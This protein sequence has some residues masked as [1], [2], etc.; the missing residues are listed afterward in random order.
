MAVGATLNIINKNKIDSWPVHKKLFDSLVKSVLL[1]TAPVW[2]L[3]YLN[4]LE[5]VQMAFIKRSL[6][7]PKYIPNHF[8]RLETG[9]TPLAT[10]IFKAC[11]NWLEK[12]QKMGNNRYPKICYNKIRDIALKSSECKIVKYNWVKQ[13]Q[14][15]FYTDEY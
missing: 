10:N 14:K 6:N 11:I 12:L 3:R 5:K 1:Y 13:V 8:V 15:A 7:L 4:D 9:R 2:S